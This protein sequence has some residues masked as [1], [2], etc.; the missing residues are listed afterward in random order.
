MEPEGYGMPDLYNQIGTLYK[1]TVQLDSASDAPRPARRRAWWNLSG[2]SI[3]NCYCLWFSFPLSIWLSSGSIGLLLYWQVLSLA[4]CLLEKFTPK[5]Q[6]A[7]ESSAAGETTAE[8]LP[9]AEY[10]P[11][12]ACCPAEGAAR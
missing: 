10:C 6:P 7:G 9:V 5:Q 3:C 4:A 1:I 2:R 11:V 8:Y 12:A